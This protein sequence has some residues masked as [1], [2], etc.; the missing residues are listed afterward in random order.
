[1]ASY[2][3]PT[4]TGSTFNSSSWVAPSASSADTAFLNANYCQFPTL[5]GAINTRSITTTGN[6]GVSS[7]IVMNGIAGTNYIQFP[8]GTQQKTATQDFSGYAFTDVSNNF[9]KLNTFN[10]NLAIGGTLGVN[11]IQYP[12]GTRQYTAP[13]GDDI[14]TVY[15]DISNTFLSGT[16]QTFQGSNAT[17]PS[18]GPLQIS[19][20]TTN[21]Y[22]SFFVDPS[23]TYDLTLYT[24]QTGNTAGLTVR[25]PDYSFSVNPTVGNVATFVNP[26]SCGTYS[27]TAGAITGTQLTLSTSGNS[28]IL[29]TG[30][31][32]LSIND[33]VIVG[34][35]L[36]L[37]VGAN[38]TTLST[39]ANGLN[40]ADPIVSTGNITGTGLTIATTGQDT[41]SIYSNSTG[42]YG[43]VLANTTGNN[44]S[45]TLSNNGGNLTTLTCSAPQTLNYNG[46]SITGLLNL[47]SNLSYINI[48]SAISMASG[49]AININSSVL[50]LYDAGLN[51]N[52][53]FAGNQC[54][55]NNGGSYT[56]NAGFNFALNNNALPSVL[57]TVLNIA[58]D[59]IDMYA[60]L[61]MNDNNITSNI[62][63]TTQLQLLSDLPAGGS[64]TF[65]NYDPN[66]FAL[67][68]FNGTGNATLAIQNS[69][70][71]II[72]FNNAGI[73][74]SESINMNG[75]DINNITTLNAGGLGGY[76]VTNTPT[77]G[78]NSLKIATTAFV[79]TAI[80][81]SGPIYTTSTFTNN[82][83][84]A[85]S[86]TITPSPV[87]VISTYNGSTNDVN[88]NNVD[89]TVSV[90][91]VGVFYLTYLCVLTFNVNPFPNSPPNQTTGS[92]TVLYKNTNTVVT[93][94]YVWTANTLSINYPSSLVPYFSNTSFTLNLQNLGVFQA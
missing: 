79:Q 49:Q 6:I 64:V 33:S 86:I 80:S 53:Y 57:S 62:I 17:L 74:S 59:E 63:F 46:G 50:Y 11:Y 72:T 41:Y 40:V 73:T 12:D 1:M 4:N 2:P 75:N 69:G 45:L 70:T 90:G 67:N 29:T 23:P 22:A 9:S 30:V 82:D 85:P 91:N 10:G 66:I 39:S 37:S 88:F 81:G 21:E 19:N 3:K 7:N 56:G 54:S 8:D 52:I 51:T 36:L 13:T 15:N 89:F 65:Y 42:G 5:Q 68:M 77:T 35:D 76:V 14:N 84:S 31:I 55:F 60:D 32:G 24:A 83:T 94:T 61:N 38:T 28:S 93:T 48:N 71:N 25:N 26:I 18:T 92:I 43:L 87:S 58:S 27:L 78:D 16:I 20:A 47:T 34:G 44:G